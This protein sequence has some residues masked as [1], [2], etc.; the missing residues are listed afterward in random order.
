MTAQVIQLPIKYE[1]TPCI[2]CGIEIVIS[3]QRMRDLR[4]TSEEFWCLNGHRQWFSGQSDA[5][6]I[7]RDL[8]AK[9]D[10]SERERVWAEN[11]QKENY[12]RAEKLK[13][14][15]DA[16]KGHLGRVKNRIAAGVCPCCNR[17]FANLARHMKTKHK[18][19]KH[20]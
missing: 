19:F 14:S 6:R 2:D 7:R 11:R 20:E 5:E 13:K 8:Q 9:L 15:R 10:Q 17:S 12:L 18:R 4:N 16:L 3:S 1:T